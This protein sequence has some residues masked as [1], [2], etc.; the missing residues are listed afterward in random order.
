MLTLG[1]TQVGRIYAGWGVGPCF[2]HNKLYL[3][4]GCPLALP[5]TLALTLTLGSTLIGSCHCIRP[6]HWVLVESRH[7][8]RHPSLVMLLADAGIPQW[9]T[10]CRGVWR[11]RS[12]SGLYDG[13]WWR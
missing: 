10:S 12:A 7:L 1:L 4:L 3:Q 5:R 8:S 11:G 9:K 6:C 13:A 2:Y